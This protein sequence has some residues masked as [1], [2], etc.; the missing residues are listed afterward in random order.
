ML[1]E[2]SKYLGPRDI[3]SLCRCSK[4]LLEFWR[5]TLYESNVQN[6][7][8]SAVSLAIKSLKRIPTTKDLEFA[9]GTINHSV[10]AKADLEMKHPADLPDSSPL[11]QSRNRVKHFLPPLFMSIALGQTKI[12]KR[13]I[14]AGAPLQLSNPLN[15]AL[16]HAAYHGSTAMVEHILKET[17]ID[18]HMEDNFGYT[19]IFSAVVGNRP[20]KKLIQLLFKHG[21]D[22]NKTITRVDRDL[23]SPLSIACD[24]GKWM[25]AELLLVLGAPTRKPDCS[26]VRSVPRGLSP[27]SRT[28]LTA[29]VL[30]ATSPSTDARSR[31]ARRRIILELLKSG[32]DPN[33]RYNHRGPI[34]R[35]SSLLFA[36]VCQ[37]R[38]WEAEMLLE[39]DT[40][41]IDTPTSDGQTT[42][43]WALSPHHGA[44]DFAALLLCKGAAIPQ[45]RAQEILRLTQEA[46]NTTNMRT[47]ADVLSENRSLARCFQVLYTHCV[48]VLREQQ[49]EIASEF[50]QNAPAFIV[51][52]VIKKNQYYAH[53]ENQNLEDAL[54]RS[55]IYQPLESERK[56]RRLS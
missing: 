40:L 56:R 3:S 49:S 33:Q 53:L 22:V 55:T 32:E 18:I 9:L 54:H 42:L 46:C 35:T 6:G 14:E 26:D 10:Q 43:N 47:V 38:Y 4:V 31:Y 1:L 16:H 20:T 19:A 34:P 25:I 41:E 24:R 8:S 36:L 51:D 29:A 27:Y 21:A 17:L 28:A 48:S 37:G 50:V 7:R 23:E 30:P 52:L 39:S 45:R 15:T 12:S 13:L 2:I 44:P 11:L 5:K